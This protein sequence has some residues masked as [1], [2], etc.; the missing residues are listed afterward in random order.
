MGHVVHCHGTTCVHAVPD[1]SI[2][3]ANEVTFKEA[4][5]RHAV[6]E[7]MPDA[8]NDVEMKVQDLGNGEVMVGPVSSKMA[9][10]A[11]CGLL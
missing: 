9:A 3:E 8:D 5:K 11:I 7:K 1:S 6:D 10:M 4:E 2:A